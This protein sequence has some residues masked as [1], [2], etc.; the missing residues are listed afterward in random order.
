MNEK[1]TIASSTRKKHSIKSIHRVNKRNG[2]Y[3]FCCKNAL[4]LLLSLIFII[5]VIVFVQNLI[6]IDQLFKSVLHNLPTTD[7]F[8]LFF[9]SE[10]LLGLIPPDIFIVW[11]KTLAHPYMAVALLSI[12]SYIGGINSYFIG[13]QA[14]R[15]A[16]LRRHVM[17]KGEKYAKQIE[18]WGQAVII[19]AALFPLPFAMVCVVAGMAKFPFKRFLIITITRI[20]RF[21][22]YAIILYSFIH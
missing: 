1:Q 6:D 14:N 21:F 20:L 3:K 18:R 22:V 13:M 8:I 16:K 2:F 4:Y 15:I 7:I 11:T 5:A 17:E 10:S 19:I 9:F 12:L